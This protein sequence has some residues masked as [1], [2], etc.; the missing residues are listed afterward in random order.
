MAVR[1]YST[2]SRFIERQPVREEDTYSDYFAHH[3]FI[4][5]ILRTR[6]F[7]INFF[8]IVE[9]RFVFPILAELIYAELCL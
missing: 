5:G 3:M 1:R 8:S 2:F 4:Q 7:G 9:F 6:R